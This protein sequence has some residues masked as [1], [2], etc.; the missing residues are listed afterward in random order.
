MGEEILNYITKIGP[1]W[2][3]IGAIL[4]LVV[5]TYVTN[6]SKKVGLRPYIEVVRTMANPNDGV[7]KKG[8]KIILTDELEEHLAKVKESGIQ[9]E[10]TLRPN[11]LK[12]KN[13]SSNPCFGLRIKGVQ[14]N[15][16]VKET[17]LDLEF[18]VL[19]G[20]EELYIPLKPTN[21]LIYQTQIMEIEYATLAN[22][23]MLYKNETTSKNGKTVEILQSIYVI[24]SWWKNEKIVK[25]TA[26]NLKWKDVN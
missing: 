18:Y 21:N 1:M 8:S 24:K 19:N 3:F 15:S 4:A 14:Q 20:D 9:N 23:K 11:F 13:L 10:L 16:N 26:S 12:V 22:E 6:K 5:N 7:F 25:T 17:F 2:G